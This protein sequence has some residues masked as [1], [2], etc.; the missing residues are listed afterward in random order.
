VKKN[1]DSE[2]QKKNREEDPSKYEFRSRY[3]GISEF[4]GKRKNEIVSTA[5]EK[6]E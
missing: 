3:Q 6:Q 4:R 2:Q 5:T 1:E